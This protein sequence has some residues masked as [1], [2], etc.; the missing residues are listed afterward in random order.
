[1]NNFKYSKY[2]IVE[3][4]TDGSLLIYNTMKRKILKISASKSDIIKDINDKCIP[5]NLEDCFKLREYGVLVDSDFDEKSYADY[6]LNK[7]VFSSQTLELTILPTNDCNFNCIY[8]YQNERTNYMTVETA[9]SII[10][11][12]EKSLRKNIHI[13]SVGW[14][15][16][17]PMLAVDIVLYIMNKIKEICKENKVILLSRMTTNGYHLTYDN[18]QGLVKAGVRYFQ[19]TIDGNRNIH[20]LQRPLKDSNKNDSYDVVFK[21]LL[22]IKR[23]KGF[24]E[25]GIRLNITPSMLPYKNEIITTMASN[26]LDKRYVM[27]FEWVRNWG[28]EKIKEHLREVADSSV[29]IDWI[30]TASEYGLN[31]SS[32]LLSEWD[33]YFC[34]AC[35]MNGFVI[36]WDGQVYKCAMAIYKEDYRLD[37][38][39]GVI[40]PNGNLRI[41]E[42]RNSKWL[43]KHEKEECGNCIFY[44][45]CFNFCCPFKSNIK[46]EKTCLSFRNLIVDYMNFYDKQNLINVME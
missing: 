40:E 34:E 9:E 11:Y 15:G 31:C 19:V 35:K 4:L 43:T 12:V 25:I 32:K 10:K 28:G 6:T 39:V 38:N 23:F 42:Y 21:N 1:M 46:H 2:N 36:D 8:C 45:L 41:D 5:E 18:F 30:K 27:L 17:E 7:T 33:T 22:D 29:V 24:F 16:G 37:N 20:N 14:F 3:R 44:P 26:F 13:L